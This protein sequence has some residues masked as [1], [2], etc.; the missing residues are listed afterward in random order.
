MGGNDS[1][2]YCQAAVQEMFIDLL[3][4]GLLIWLDDLLGYENSESQLLKLLEK[5]LKICQQRG[6]KL[7]PK[8]C[9]F[10]KKEAKCCG[11]I[12]SS[13]GVAHDPEQIKALQDL[14][15]PSSGKDLQQF[16]CAMNW[17]RQ[18]IPGY[19]KQVKPLMDFME[20]VYQKAGDQTRQRVAKVDL[21]EAGWST[22]E[23]NCLSV[24]LS[25]WH[26][27]TQRK[28]A[29]CVHRYQ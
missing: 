25:P 11:R 3:Y 21:L 16:V 12:I 18:S 26:I 22:I 5:V 1:V 24:K 20:K 28:T 9:S 29:L 23:D 6:L 14:P 10:F 17:M 8:K 2:V 27:Q 19:N 7:N 13:Q 15:A 4:Q